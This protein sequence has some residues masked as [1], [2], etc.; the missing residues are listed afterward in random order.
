MW[1]KIAIK[2]SVGEK[3]E[4]SL[5][6]FQTPCACPLLSRRFSR[7]QRAFDFDLFRFI[8]CSFAALN[9]FKMRQ[10]V[11]YSKWVAQQNEAVA[12]LIPVILWSQRRSVRSAVDSGSVPNFM[13]P[14]KVGNNWCSH[15]C[16]TE[17]IGL[18]H[19]YM[20]W[21]SVLAVNCWYGCTMLTMRVQ[22]FV[23]GCVGRIFSSTNLN[24]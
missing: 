7:S 23:G 21:I 12:V 9:S 18:T 14:T 10:P 15:I 19:L 17:V 16:R 11:N 1:S 24:H 6:A 8:F 22:R 4:S 5:M 2:Q 20:Q 13:Y 3:L